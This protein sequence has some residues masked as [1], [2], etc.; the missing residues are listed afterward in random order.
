MLTGDD[1]R[2]RL[3]FVGYKGSNASAQDAAEDP[4]YQV[5]LP[6]NFLVND[7][8]CQASPALLQSEQYVS[9]PKTAIRLSRPGI[10]LHYLPLEFKRLR[11]STGLFA[12]HTQFA[13]R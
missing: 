5:A 8:T 7:W 4:V 12:S 9:R 2:V 10:E 1:S 13:F 3:G 11:F 6:E